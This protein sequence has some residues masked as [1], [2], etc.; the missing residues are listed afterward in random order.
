MNAVA[1]VLTLIAV[2]WA[3]MLIRGIVRRSHGDDDA[4]DM[5]DAD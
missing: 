4:D 5:D 3:G 2:L 1:A